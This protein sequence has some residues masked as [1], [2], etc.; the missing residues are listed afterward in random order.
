VPRTF[1]VLHSGS[2]VRPGFEL[3]VDG[4]TGVRTRL[5]PLLTPT[6]PAFN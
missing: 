3:E 1:D 4:N 5:V 2:A 6:A